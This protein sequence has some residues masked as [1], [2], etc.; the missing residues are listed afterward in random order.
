MKYGEL[1]LEKREYDFLKRILSLTKYYKDSSYKAS[2]YK[3]NKELKEAR[4][5][6]NNEMP[7]DIVRLNS[8]VT[9][10]TPYEVERTYQIVTPDKGDIRNNRI[11]VLAP[12]GLALIGYAQ[13]DDITWNFPLGESN[14]KIKNLKQ[15]ES[16]LMD[17]N[18]GKQHS[19][20]P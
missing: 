15:V 9:I 14:I 20:T 10:R 11:S 18:Y 2:I 17:I 6:S 4:I 1:I 12:M 5:V 16:E 19:G 13:G 7:V 8:F 3:L